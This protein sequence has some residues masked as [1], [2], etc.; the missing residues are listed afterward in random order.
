MAVE[1]FHVAVKG[2][3]SS[4]AVAVGPQPGT[5]G[6]LGGGTVTTA[7]SNVGNGVIKYSAEEVEAITQGACTHEIKVESGIEQWKIIK[8]SGEEAEVPKFVKSFC[9]SGNIP[10]TC[11]TVKTSAWKITNP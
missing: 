5:I 11:Y 1:E 9:G 6:K 8:I 2:E 4:L 10:G 3:P 7:G